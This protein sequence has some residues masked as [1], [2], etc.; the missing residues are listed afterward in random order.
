ME[1]IEPYL[2]NPA[3]DGWFGSLATLAVILV[4]VGIIVLV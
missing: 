4:F 1:D 2:N 3:R